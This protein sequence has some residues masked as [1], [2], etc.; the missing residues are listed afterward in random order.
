MLQDRAVV[1][2]KLHKEIIELNESKMS[3]ENKLDEQERKSRNQQ[4]E[5]YELKEQL[6]HNQADLKLKAAH[7][8][9]ESRALPNLFSKKNRTQS[10]A[11][12]HTRLEICALRCFIRTCAHGEAEVEG[13]PAGRGRGEAEGAGAR[14]ARSG[15]AREGVQGEQIS[16]GKSMCDDL[17]L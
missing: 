17:S 12:K 14:Q 16:I 1:E 8:E 15:R 6:T 2:G 3:L 9:G 4:E 7:F 11:L 5:I 13:R 10:H